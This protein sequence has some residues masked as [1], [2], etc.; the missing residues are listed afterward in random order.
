MHSCRERTSKVPRWL[1]LS[2]LAYRGEQ[3]VDRRRCLVVDRVQPFEEPWGP[4]HS[5][6]QLPLESPDD[7]TVPAHLEGSG[8]TVYRLEERLRNMDAGSHDYSDEY[9]PPSVVL[10]QRSV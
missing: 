2:C 3:L 5:W 9:T 8:F 4:V 10:R 1:R 6:R 7:P